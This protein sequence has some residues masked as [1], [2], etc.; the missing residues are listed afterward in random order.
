VG[1]LRNDLYA[2]RLIWGRT[3]KIVSPAT[4]RELIRPTV[5]AAVTAEVPELAIVTRELF[6]AAATRKAA[7]AKVHPGQQRKRTHLLSGLLRCGACGAGLYVHGVNKH[8]QRRLACSRERESGDC[9]D[10]H[11]YMLPTVERAV[12]AGL[13]TELAQPAAL[14]EFWRSYEEE[15]KLIA[16]TSGAR[17]L[18]LER[19]I[20]QAERRLARVVNC[21]AD[22]H[23]EPA[24]LGPQAT[25]MH[26]RLEAL[27]DQ[28][29]LLGDS[30]EVVRFHRASIERYHHYVEHL[31]DTLSTDS[32]SYYAAVDAVRSLIEAVAVWRGDAYGRVRALIRGRIAALFE[33]TEEQMGNQMWGTAERVMGIEPTS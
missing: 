26:Q 9:R 8:G 19:E 14:A 22:G 32:P 5:D 17:R 7:M 11:T 3:R 21:I 24:V 23:G 6:E 12:L 28:L 10:P 1:I 30:V 33:G 4:G 29:A 18:E 13:R 25:L 20:A 15:S 27:R 31:S 16:A 2:G